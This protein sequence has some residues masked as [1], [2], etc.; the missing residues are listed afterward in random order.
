M[1][2]P[3]WTSPTVDLALRQGGCTCSQWHPGAPRLPRTAA[4]VAALVR[5]KLPMPGSSVDRT[6]TTLPPRN[7]RAVAGLCRG[8]TAWVDLL[9]AGDF[10]G[11]PTP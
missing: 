3:I 7:G 6:S 9:L 5:Q 8:C 1:P 2:S 10:G 11:F 4:P